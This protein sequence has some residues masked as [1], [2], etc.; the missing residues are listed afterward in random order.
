MPAVFAILLT[1]CVG[2]PADDATGQEIYLQLCSNCH[3]DQL[4]GGLVGP[5]LGPGST[6][7][8]LPDEFL[9]V[10][11]LQGRGSMPSFESSL[12]DDQVDRLV[13]YIREVQAR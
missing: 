4:E 9:R 13:A 3:S 5:A 2:R 8:E 6:S 12:S 11:I 7:A 1:S 10:S